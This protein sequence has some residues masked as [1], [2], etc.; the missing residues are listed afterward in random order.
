ME[1]METNGSSVASSK[2]QFHFKAPVLPYY[3]LK[4]IKE[5]GHHYYIT[6]KNQQAKPRES[7]ASP[8]NDNDNVFLLSFTH[9]SIK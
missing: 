3:I 7:S 1:K 6:F 5:T 2:F 8:V 9:K 4:P